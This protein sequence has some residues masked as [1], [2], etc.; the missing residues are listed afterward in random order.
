MLKTIWVI[1]VAVVVLFAIVALFRPRILW[2]ISLLP[3]LAGRSPHDPPRFV[4]T[5]G[6]IMSALAIA[7]GV[8]ILILGL[9][10]SS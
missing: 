2:R 8:F 10:S 6:R 9:R 5:A 1:I 7:V 3:Y 4:N